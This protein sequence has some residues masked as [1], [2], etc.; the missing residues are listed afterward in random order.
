M[1]RGLSVRGGLSGSLGALPSRWLGPDLSEQWKARFEH[2][3]TPAKPHVELD[4]GLELSLSAQRA[5]PDDRDPPPRFEK[6]VLVAPVPLHV[7][8]ELCL[9]Q[10]LAGGWSGRMQ[11]PGVAVPKAA[12]DE[13]HG[14]ESTKDQI[15]RTGKSAVVQAVPQAACVDSPPKGEF[16][17]SVSATNRRHHA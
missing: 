8:M 3:A 7:R 10:L 11:T 14:S 13:A 9:P 5:L 2:L 17:R 4:D 6:I 12:M 1:W 16:G 15:G